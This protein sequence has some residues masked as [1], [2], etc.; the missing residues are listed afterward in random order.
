MSAKARRIT[1][2]VLVSGGLLALVIS[3]LDT[4]TALDRLQQAEWPWL[5][6]AFGVSLLVLLARGLRF[7]LL[8]RQS[9]L[10]VVTAAIATQNFLTR[11]T[12]LRLGEL[13]LPYLL[14][15]TVGEPP[16]P[17]LVSLVLVRLVELWVLIGLVVAAGVAWFGSA[18]VTTTLV[19]AGILGGMTL[20]LAFFRP[21]LAFAVRAFEALVKHLGLDGVGLVSKALGQLQGAV[22]GEHRLDR[23]QRFALAAGTVLVLGL[24]LVLYD[25]L[26]RACGL[27]LDWRQVVVGSTA[28]QVVGAL[29]VATV[30]SLGTH[31]TGWTAGFM[32]VGL[33]LTDAV[34]SGLLTQVITLIF[35]GVFALPGWAWLARFGRSKTAP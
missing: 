14:H 30:G 4:A 5:L 18:E 10:K 17:A 7:A 25:T 20:A 1:L 3:R 22:A 35:A 8:C 2:G 19:L 32:W 6:A 28:A 31:E 27:H 29:P 9:P 12:P 34:V 26:L 24:Q 16:A 23:R 15:R 33:S 13:S 11:I 21:L